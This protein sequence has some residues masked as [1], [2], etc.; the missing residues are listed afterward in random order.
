MARL[1]DNDED[2]DSLMIIGKQEHTFAPTLQNQ[3][4]RANNDNTINRQHVVIQTKDNNN[5]SVL[6]VSIAS[7]NSESVIATHQN[8]T[9]THAFSNVDAS[10]PN[11]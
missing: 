3:M 11:G 7:N 10:L 4:H 5:L 8:R 6:D 1:L 9:S 2:N